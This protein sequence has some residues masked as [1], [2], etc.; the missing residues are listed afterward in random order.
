MTLGLLPSATSDTRGHLAAAA[1]APT[2]RAERVGGGGAP[3]K[4]DDCGRVVVPFVAGMLQAQTWA[5]VWSQSDAPQFVRLDRSDPTAYARLICDL[6]D[7][8]QGFTIVEQ[9]IVAPPGSLAAVH[10]CEHPWCV[11]PYSVGRAPTS[12]MLGLVRFS[13]ALVAAMP[14]LAR[15]SLARRPKRGGWTKYRGVDLA[16]ARPFQQAGIVHHDHWPVA[17]HLHRYA[18]PTDPGS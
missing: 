8:G 7:A 14:A 16:L 18:D 17:E 10:A 5:S 1:P 13:T 2:V 12:P 11:H 3:G 6:W 9:D 15:K 4:R